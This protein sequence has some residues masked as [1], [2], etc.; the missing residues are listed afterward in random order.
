MKKFFMYFMMFIA[1]YL[2]VNIFTNLGM[3]ENY[4]DITN[5]QIN[6]TT[7][8]VTVSESKAT[9]YYGYIKGNILNN[10]GE[11]IKDKYLQFDFY[12][13]NGVYL[14]TEAKEIKYFNV[15]ETINFEM[16]YKYHNVNKIEI[17]FVDE[18]VKLKEKSFN[19][20]ENIDEGTL[21]IAI[22]I[23]MVLGLYVILP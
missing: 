15:D 2:F 14:G 6:I 19:I 11:H 10:T 3:R 20:F 8:Q 18:V 17:S 4:K 9:N 22:P 13:K 21:K 5:H 23:A 16:N 7:P 12:N 1:L